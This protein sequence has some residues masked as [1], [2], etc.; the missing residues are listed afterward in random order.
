MANITVKNSIIRKIKITDRNVNDL[1][2]V[3]RINLDK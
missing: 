2:F 3:G 1:L